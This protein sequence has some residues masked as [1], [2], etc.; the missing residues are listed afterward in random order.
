M[1]VVLEA[2]GAI[3]DVKGWRLRKQSAFIDNSMKWPAINMASFR[4]RGL[5]LSTFLVLHNVIFWKNSTV[6]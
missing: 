3:N 2:W 6:R 5:M 4:T 1:F